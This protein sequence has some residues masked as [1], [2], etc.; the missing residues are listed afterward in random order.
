MIQLFF[1]KTDFRFV[2]IMFN[3]TSGKTKIGISKNVESRRTDIDKEVE[4]R[5]VVLTAHRFFSAEKV[6]VSLHRRFK[7]YHAPMRS[8]TGKTEWFQMP[9]PVRTWLMFF[10]W[11]MWLEQRFLTVVIFSGML[12]FGWLARY[13]VIE[14]INYLTKNIN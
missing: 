6:E 5:V 9:F 11:L 13:R 12:F 8:G 4:G 10:L 14:L 3:P 2:Y 7:K 1:R